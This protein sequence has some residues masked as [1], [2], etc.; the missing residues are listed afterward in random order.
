MLIICRYSVPAAVKSHMTMIQPTTRFG[1]IR[2]KRPGGLNNTDVDFEQSEVKVEIPNPINPSLSTT[3]CNSN[4][5]P[6][7]LRALYRIGNYTADPSVRSIVGVAGFLEV[8]VECNI[9][10]ISPAVAHTV[11]RN[12]QNST[13]LTCFLVNLRH[14]PQLRTSATSSSTTDKTIKQTQ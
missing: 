13:T 11:L 14:M 10:N 8:S 1:Q 3:F 4:V 6:D 2:P 7:C 9:E 5:N 12:G